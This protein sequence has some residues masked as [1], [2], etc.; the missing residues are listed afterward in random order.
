MARIRIWHDPCYAR[1][2][3]NANKVQPTVAECATWLDYDMWARL[4]YEVDHES[5]S[6]A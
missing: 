3:P 2:R 1:S 5:W 4:R 6:V